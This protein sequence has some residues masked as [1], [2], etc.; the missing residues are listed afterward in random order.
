MTNTLSRRLLG[1][2]SKAVL[3][4]AAIGAAGFFAPQAANADV[5]TIG[6]GI[7]GG[8]PTVV[9]SGTSKSNYS[10][11]SYNG[12]S[13]SVTGK[14]NPP[15]TL[16][17]LLDSNT[18]DVTSVGGTANVLDVYVTESDITTPTGLE[19]FISDFTSN[20]LPA[21][22]TVIE[23][24]YVDP[25]DGTLAAGKVDLVGSQT[26]VGP[27]STGTGSGEAVW[28][29]GSGPYSATVEYQVTSNLTGGT[30][31]DTIDV[32]VPEPMSLT[33]FGAALVGLGAVRRRKRKQA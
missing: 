32:L 4:A 11:P 25:G 2:T 29:V 30:T 14:G 3:F 1:G 24:A 5:I 17:N 7:N 26:F 9:A 16:P 28:N 10:N 27:L 8:A 19:N 12:Y 22:W 21:S 15:L 13:V 6:L 23:M 31:N 18:L 20:S 33:L